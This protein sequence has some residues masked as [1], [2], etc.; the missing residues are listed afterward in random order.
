METVKTSDLQPQVDRLARVILS[1]PWLEI[2]S[3]ALKAAR[4]LWQGMADEGVYEVLEHERTSERGRT[5][6]NLPFS[7]VSKVQ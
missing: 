3:A 7:P 2:L 1:L 5:L 4:K 6:R